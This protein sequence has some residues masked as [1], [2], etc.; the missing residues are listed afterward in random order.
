M[1][2]TLSSGLRMMLMLNVPATMGLMTL[3]WPIIA[4]IFQHGSFTRGDADATAVALA[5]YAP[6]LIGYSA[7][8]LAAPA[9]YALH[10]SRTPVMVSVVSVG[11]NVTLNL[12][13]VQSLGY[14]GL[15][16]GTAT[17]ALFNAGLLLWLLR[18]RL[19]GLDEARVGAAFGKIVLASLV[20]ALAAWR[21]DVL[22]AAAM[23]ESQASALWT[24]LVRLVR[25]TA[26]IGGALVVLALTARLFR[27]QELT[28]ALAMLRARLSRPDKPSL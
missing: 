26:D 16:L 15:A 8:R 25:V 22:L 18:L 21:L 9:F 19:G 23:P 7:V 27:L 11:L 5:C 28:D 24:L 10:D 1:R 17:A 2:R 4:L 12:A 20:M 3:A 6:G 13:L 14:A